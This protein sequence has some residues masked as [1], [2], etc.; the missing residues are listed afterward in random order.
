[1]TKYKEICIFRLYHSAVTKS[2]LFVIFK[3]RYRGERDSVA[4]YVQLL[5]RKCAA[6][7]VMRYKG[8]TI[9]ADCGRDIENHRPQILLDVAD[10]LSP[11]ADDFRH[12]VNNFVKPVPVKHHILHENVI[13][14]IVLD[15]LPVNLVCAV[16]RYFLL[17]TKI[18]PAAQLERFQIQHFEQLMT[19]GFPYP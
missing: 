7:H 11:G 8:R 15:D 3:K 5:W 10:C 4:C 6:C 2:I 12:E 18:F 9:I 19:T 17:R 1:M 13:V 14:D 16:S